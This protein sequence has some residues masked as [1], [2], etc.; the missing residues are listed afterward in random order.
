MKNMKVNPS[1]F[2][3]VPN[4][5]AEQRRTGFSHRFANT[6]TDSKKRKKALAAADRTLAQAK[7]DAKIKMKKKLAQAYK[8]PSLPALTEAAKYN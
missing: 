8:S 6:P 1:E 3:A 2:H 5:A 4:S 7:E